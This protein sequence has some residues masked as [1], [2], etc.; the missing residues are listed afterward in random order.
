MTVPSMVGLPPLP[1]DVPA[2]ADFPDRFPLSEFQAASS[3][4]LTGT[5][6]RWAWWW[7]T[8]VLMPARRALGAILITSY[9]R[10]SNPDTGIR[11][12]GAHAASNDGGWALDLVPL[13]TETVALKDWLATHRIEYLGELLDE[14]D[15]VHLT[16]RG[17]GGVG[18]VLTQLEDGSWAPGFARPALLPLIAI[19]ALLALIWIR[20]G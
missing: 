3:R 4:R 15:H 6:I 20:G 11:E 17:V 5:E 19:A 7:A 12:D 1:L 16:V 18:Q 2:A 13:E 10:A 8:Y 9:E 14:R